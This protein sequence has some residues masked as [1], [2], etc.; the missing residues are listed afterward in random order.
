MK[1][2]GD[3][4]SYCDSR[5]VFPKNWLRRRLSHMGLEVT[6]VHF[7][8]F[9]IGLFCAVDSVSF[10]TESVVS[11]VT[12][13]GDGIPMATATRSGGGGSGCSGG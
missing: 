4:S 11:D 3:I 6:G 2:K 7:D 5:G 1:A 9:D 8:V 12:G 10:G 13:D